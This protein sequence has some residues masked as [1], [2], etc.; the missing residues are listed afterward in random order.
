MLN[1]RYPICNSAWNPPPVCFMT[2][3]DNIR[4]V[5]YHGLSTYGYDPTQIVAGTA[6]V[7]WRTLIEK[8]GPVRCQSNED[9]VVA[10]QREYPVMV[11]PSGGGWELSRSLPQLVCCRASLSLNLLYHLVYRFHPLFSSGLAIPAVRSPK[12]SAH[13]TPFP[14][15]AHS[16]PFGRLSIVR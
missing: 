6:G 10:Q 15:H 3:I 7:R 14:A 12:C 9:L 4:E 8:Q 2:T 13:Q 1:T 5:H 11:C 16:L